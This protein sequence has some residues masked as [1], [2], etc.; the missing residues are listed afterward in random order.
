MV[1]QSNK[2]NHEKCKKHSKFIIF[3]YYF[4]KKQME[5]LH[6]RKVLRV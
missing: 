1:E 2:K 4:F 3:L 6:L 5:T